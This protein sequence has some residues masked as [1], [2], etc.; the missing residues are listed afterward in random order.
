MLMLFKFLP[1]RTLR[2]ARV[3]FAGIT[4]VSLAARPVAA[5]PLLDYGFDETGTQA[6]AAGTAADGGGNPRLEMTNNSGSAADLHGAPGT[7]VSG[8][9]GDR[10]LDNTLSSGILSASS[11]RHTADFD[12]I[13]G[14]TAFTLSGWFKLPSTANES[15]GRQAALI[16]N[17]TISVL[18][19][20]GGFRLRGGAV[21]DSGTLELRVN[22]DFMV[23]SSAV[24]D[25]IGEY[26]NF[27][28]TYNGALASNNVQFFKGTT[29]SPLTLVDTL[30]LNAG[31]VG[32]ESIPL[33]LGVTRTSGLTLNPFNGLLDN[34]RIF[35]SVVPLGELESLR[36][37]D[38]GVPEPGAAMLAVVGLLGL[39]CVSRRR[40]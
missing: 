4:L 7:G 10:A 14:L 37:G 11:A 32:G 30:T 20:L 17:G 29:T 5:A 3:L 39:A 2:G 9:A 36:Q 19:N 8:A 31:P 40:G 22:R 23:E 38:A 6:L 13:D 24:Y 18:D 33:T 16:E 35:G 27:A 1:K 28:V 21:A 34:I 15:I 26:V 12:A 25:E